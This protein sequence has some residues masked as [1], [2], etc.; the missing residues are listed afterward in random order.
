MHPLC[1][2]GMCF[3]EQALRS[4]QENDNQNHICDRVL[5]AGGDVSCAQAFG[6]TH[7]QTAEHGSRN[8]SDTTENRINEAVTQEDSQSTGVE[9]RV[10]GEVVASSEV[11]LPGAI[12]L[13]GSEK[14]SEVDE[15]TLARK[16]AK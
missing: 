8:T 15:S 11:R 14:S 6:Y 10:Q 5:I 7:D 2:I 1:L 12:A 4:N 13:M 9:N 16:A 3:S